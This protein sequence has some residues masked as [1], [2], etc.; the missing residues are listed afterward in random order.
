LTRKANSQWLL[1]QLGWN[2]FHF[3]AFLYA[4]DVLIFFSPTEL[5]LRVIKGVLTLFEGESGLAANLSK[6]HAYRIN[7]SDEEISLAC[8]SDEQIFLYCRFPL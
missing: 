4:D 3:R 2:D 5:D 7:C 8:S 1:Q 6:S